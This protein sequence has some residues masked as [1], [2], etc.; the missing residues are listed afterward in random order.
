MVLHYSDELLI[1][2]DPNGGKYGDWILKKDSANV[3][4]RF[5]S[6][7]VRLSEGVKALSK[8]SGTA[9]HKNASLHAASP[10]LSS[11]RSRHK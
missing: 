4:C 5:C 1:I 11:V 7:N 6:T 10:E 3:T 8:H 9:K 2:N